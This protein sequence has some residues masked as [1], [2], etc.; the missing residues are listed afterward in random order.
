MEAGNR[1]HEGTEEKQ[2]AGAGEVSHLRDV[3]ETGG[4]GRRLFFFFFLPPPLRSC[5]R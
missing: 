2:V 4:A 3:G 1:Q 5:G